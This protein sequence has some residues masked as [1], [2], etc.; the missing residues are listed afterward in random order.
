ME[1]ATCRPSGDSAQAD[2]LHFST[3]SKQDLTPLHI[4]C[5]SRLIFSEIKCSLVVCIKLY[6]YI[7]R[8]FR[9]L[10]VCILIETRDFIL[11]HQIRWR[12]WSYSDTSS[13]HSGRLQITTQ[14]W[15]HLLLVV[16]CFWGLPSVQTF[17]AYLRDGDSDSTSGINH[18]NLLEMFTPMTH[19]QVTWSV[20]WRT[21]QECGVLRPS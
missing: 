4:E 3:G 13:R 10:N 2:M 14:T 15:S 17:S 9:S 5:L 1:E 8:V 18:Y 16:R 11:L 6:R 19:D 12:T 7:F 20:L 21:P